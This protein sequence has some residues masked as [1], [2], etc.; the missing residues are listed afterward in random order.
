MAADILLY[1]M[2]LVGQGLACVLAFHGQNVFEGLLFRTEDLNFL[3]VV[4]KA[5]AEH[6]ASVGEVV[7]F[8]LEMGSVLGTLVHFGRCA[9]G[10]FLTH[11]FIF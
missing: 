5:L 7:Q 2:E 8:S 1:A 9:T 6:A 3:L 10:E 4:G 11:Y